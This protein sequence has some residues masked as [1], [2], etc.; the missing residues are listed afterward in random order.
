MSEITKPILL[1]DT[2]AEKMDAQNLLL[3]GILGAQGGTVKPTTM[4]QAA[5]LVR[6]GL[7]ERVFHPGDQLISTWKDVATDTEY[8]APWNVLG[9][10]DVTLE[11][12]SVVPGMYIQLA[13][14]TPFGVQFSNA[15]A[16]YYAATELP[17]GTYHFTL[18]RNWGTHTKAGKTYQFTLTKPV[19]AGGQLR[20]MVQMPEQAPANWRISSYA[21][22]TTTTAIETVTPTEGS[23]GTDM[24]TMPY[25]TTFSTGTYQLN[26]MQRTAY[27]DNQWKGSAM[28]QW[29]NSDADKGKWW[30]PKNEYDVPP[31]QLPDKAGFLSGLSK[32]FLDAIRPVKV[33]TYRNTTALDGTA[34]ITYD[35]VFLLSLEEEY[36]DT[37][38]EGEGEP[39]D[40]WKLAAGTTS[41]TPW[42]K[43][44]PNMVTYALE[45]N[46]SPQYV[47]LRSASRGAAYITWH[48]SASG[49]VNYGAIVC[50]S[51]RVAPA[52]VIC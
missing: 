48:V 5:A 35:R 23:G 19:P 38:I 29:L 30:K 26:N 34:D 20:G 46:T 44:T 27:G 11:D 21:N 2:Y 37:Q 28:E 50:A 47:R 8:T 31:T 32:D 36:I 41:P 45:D 14:A 3:A 51:N 1:N 4:Q 22:N 9:F 42:Y 10:R 6:A 15:Q 7:G 16:F 17:A 43:N 52:C 18:G 25:D 12:G 24:G 39:F 33:T 49:Y 40:Y 13:Y